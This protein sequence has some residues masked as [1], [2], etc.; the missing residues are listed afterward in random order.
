ML[1]SK[2]FRNG[3][4]RVSLAA[5]LVAG[6]TIGCGTSPVG[7]TDVPSVSGPT[8]SSNAMPLQIQRFGW[9]VT[10]PSL[11]VNPSL[12]SPVPGGLGT[13]AL[14]RYNPTNQAFAMS[15]GT[16]RFMISVNNDSSGYAWP[17][18]NQVAH[19]KVDGVDKYVD[20]PDIWNSM[21]YVDVSVAPGS[22]TV[23]L[24]EDYWAT[25]DLVGNTASNFTIS[26]GQLKQQGADFDDKDCHPSCPF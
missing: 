8:A 6:P 22:H 12:K 15:N 16:L 11:A 1:V 21:A 4:F 19:I 26:S 3:A 13:K 25:H 18:A 5:I 10:D 24:V 7:N 17:S 23:V 20:Q 14:F 2:M 9:R